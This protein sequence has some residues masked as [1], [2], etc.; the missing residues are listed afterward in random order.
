MDILILP[1]DDIG[2][3]ISAATRKVLNAADT[4]FGLDL[5][6]EERPIGV[7]AFKETGSTVPEDTVAAAMAADGVILGPA[8]M[9]DYPEGSKGWLNVPGTIRK[10]LDL[11]ANVRP[12]RSREGV[13]G[14]RQGLD[15]TIVR[16]NTEGFYSDRNMFK[17]IG[18]FMPTEDVALSVRKITRPASHRIAK[19][20]FEVA[21][22]KGGHVTAVGKRHVLQ[23]SDGLFIEEVENVAADYP[24]VE[25]REMDIDAIAADLYSHPE[26]FDVI[27]IT[28]MFGDILSNAAVA[29]SGS[30]G[31]AA[32]INAGDNRAIANAGHG[33][34]PDIA[35]QG[36]ANPS[37]LILSATMLIEWM[38][39]KKG[40]NSYADAAAAI[41]RSVDTV[42]TNVETRTRDLGGAC[43][44]EDFADAIIAKL[45]AD[46]L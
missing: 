8:G 11:Y 16:E 18:E 28:N 4:I 5:N 14:A 17:G 21:H 23:V 30:L 2:P 38:G 22:R 9:T 6:F 37:G 20:A 40:L 19:V 44:T 42:L 3:E 31:L 33:S 24:S 1:G 46:N 34:A 26:K 13:P 43:S 12:A 35:G 41:H 7:A 36:I 25:W 27:L 39:D 10:R 45:H 29:M 32:A 15:V